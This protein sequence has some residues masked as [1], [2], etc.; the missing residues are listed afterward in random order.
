MRFSAKTR[1]CLKCETTPVLTD[2]TLLRVLES[3]AM[4][5]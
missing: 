2:G 5:G 3:S 1:G 4:K